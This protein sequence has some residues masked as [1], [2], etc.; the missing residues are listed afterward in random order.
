[1]IRFNGVHKSFGPKRVLTGLDLEIRTGETLAVI[2]QSGSGKSVLLKILIGILAPER[3][4][5]F[6]DDV[7]VTALGRDERQ[8]TARKFGMLFQAAALFDSLNVAEN[9][10]FGLRRRM[11]LSEQEIA[12]LVAD[13]LAK[14]GLRGI[15]KLMPHE[16]SGGM[17]KRVGLAR[18]IAYRPEIILYDEPSTGLDP[19]RADA[20]NDLILLLQK[21]MG[22]TSIVITHDMVSAYKVADRIAMLY[23]GKIIAVG[24]PEE[25]RHSPD[26]VVQ[27][28]LQGRA[29]GPIKDF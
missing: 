7:E 27:Q 2:G 21:E 6:V 25:I 16:L 24:P 12:G 20:I 18:A 3:G 10:A 23:G 22:V 1:M 17:R 29:E 26:P 15:E 13:S 11:R 9:V 8:A 14:V 4:K 5:V 19:I 28:F